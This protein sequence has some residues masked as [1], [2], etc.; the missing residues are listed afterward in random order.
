MHHYGQSCACWVLSLFSCVQLFNPMDSNPP[1]SC[2]WDSPGKNT[3][4]VS[5]TSLNVYQIIQLLK[6]KLQELFLILSYSL[7]FFLIFG[8]NIITMQCQF[9][10]YNNVNQL[11]VYI[12]GPSWTSS[13]APAHRS[14]SW[15]SAGLS[16][17]CQQQLPT[18][19]LLCTWQY[20]E[21]TA[22]LSVPLTLRSPLHPVSTCL[23]AKPASLFLYLPH[24]I[25]QKILLT[26][27]PKVSPVNPLLVTSAPTIVQYRSQSLSCA[28]SPR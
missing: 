16:S 9:L 20:T 26:L 18:G 25:H 7:F 23:F 27:S 19:Y 22:A 4:V 6:P 15:L 14:E 21:S 24:I 17:L 12:H 1:G 5:S 10:P 11:Y 2:P 13:P 28:Q 3:R 8:W